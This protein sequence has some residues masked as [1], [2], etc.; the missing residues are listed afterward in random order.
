VERRR[1]QRK[2]VQFFCFFL[3]HFW[4]M[5]WAVQY[6]LGPVFPVVSHLCQWWSEK[7]HVVAAAAR[8]DA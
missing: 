7:S 2:Y 4:N 6:Y 5:K 3:F 1:I 8:E